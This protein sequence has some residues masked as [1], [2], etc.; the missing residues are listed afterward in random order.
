MKHV[1][2]SLLVLLCAAFA[3]TASAQ[4]APAKT[5]PSN[6]TERN[7]KREGAITGRVIGPDGQPAP[8][9]S[10]STYRISERQ[11]PGHS[12][13]T[14][15]DGNFKLTGL[16]PG[17]YV[18]RAGAPGYIAAEAPTE[19]AVHRIGENVTINLVKGGVVTGRVTD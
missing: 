3:Q 10:V 19:N 15:D 16:S 9:A 12:A 11:G 2:I 7:S 6:Q 4:E 13:T 5:A 18:L 14:D 8:D 1:I 17:A